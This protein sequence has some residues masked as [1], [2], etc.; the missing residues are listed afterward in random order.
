MH[1]RHA[2]RRSAKWL[3]H[4][5]GDQEGLVLRPAVEALGAA[6]LLDPKGS[7]CA[8]WLTLLGGRAV[9]DDALYDD[10]GRPFLLGLERLQRAGQRVEVV[11]V[12][13]PLNRPAVALESGCNVLGEGEI[14]AAF[15][16]DLVVVVDP[17]QVRQLLMSGE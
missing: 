6:D 16:G 9:A 10:H 4:L 17:A 1:P 5:V 15:D 13:D 8:E 11:G 12:V 7:P 14:G 2:Y 3:P